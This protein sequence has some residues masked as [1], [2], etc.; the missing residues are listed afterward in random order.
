MSREDFYKNQ[1]NSLRNYIA[2]IKTD[3]ARRKRGEPQVF[4][5]CGPSAVGKTTVQKHVSASLPR[6]H[7]AVSHTT[8][9]PR[10]GEVDGEDYMFISEERFDE[11]EAK[12]LFAETTTYAGNRY[13]LHVDEILEPLSDGKSVVV[14]VD[15][16]G[17]LDIQGSKFI[18]SDIVHSFLIMAKNLSS[19]EDR[20]RRRGAPIRERMAIAATDNVPASFFDRIFVSEDGALDTLCSQVE[21]AIGDIIHRS[22]WQ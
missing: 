11:L 9:E 17:L 21:Q 3:M 7:L 18:D 8:R 10:E 1:I 5:I 4:A 6:I 20:L 15:R 12:N 19:I 2:R 22:A 13:G 14:V 16:K